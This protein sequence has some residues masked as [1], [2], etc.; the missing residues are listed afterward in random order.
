MIS[1]CFHNFAKTTVF[2]AV[3]IKVFYK[4]F[5]II[6]YNTCNYAKIGRIFKGFTVL[7]AF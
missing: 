1:E 6:R 5:V 4:I 2:I 3:F 7:T